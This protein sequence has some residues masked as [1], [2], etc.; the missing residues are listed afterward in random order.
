MINM[1]G[2]TNMSRYLFDYD[3]GDYIMCISN[4]MAMDSDGDLMMRMGETMAMNMDT[5]ELHI[6]SRW[7]NDDD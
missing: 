6:I 7:S 3:D 4:T 1:I 5:G 2:D